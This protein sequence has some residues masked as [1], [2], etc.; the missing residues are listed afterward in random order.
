MKTV[1]ITGANRGIGLELAKQYYAN[2]WRVFAGCRDEKKSQ[3]LK[4]ISADPKKFSILPLDVGN[5]EQI[6]SASKQLKEFPIDLLINNAGIIGYAN[7]F[8]KLE[9]KIW[10]ET[11]K[12]NS[13]APILM[14][15]A[16]L[17]QI[18]QSELKIIANI[19][20]TMGSISLNGD[21]GYYPYRSS[22][23]AL[24]SLSKNL[25]IDLKPQK[26]IVVTLHPGWVKTDM[27][28]KNA[29]VTPEESVKGL[30]KI[31]D[32]LSMKD[33]GTFISYDGQRLS[34]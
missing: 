18:E 15:Q 31:L 13:I 14:A 11:F 25:A 33:S 29:P 23:T 6:K 7:P 4:K 34:W 20:S 28:G 32:S 30:R 3:D 8:G 17:D 19:S 2:G 22:K 24:N 21:G 16:F 5:I 12:V 26:I 9:E 27:G 1:L 10:L